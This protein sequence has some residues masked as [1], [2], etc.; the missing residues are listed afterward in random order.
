MVSI[1]RMPIIR[2]ILRHQHMVPR[3]KTGMRLP[4]RLPSHRTHPQTTIVHRTNSNHNKHTKTHHHNR[5]HLHHQNN[6]QR[7]QRRTNQRTAEKTIKT[8]KNET[9]SVSGPSKP[10]YT[11][12]LTTNAGGLGVDGVYSPARAPFLIQIFR[13]K[14]TQ[15]LLDFI[16]SNLSSCTR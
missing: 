16:T 11:I 14:Q 3:E 10:Y 13:D 6:P 15:L 2:T 4:I 9:P 1:R 8:W 12:E 5:H 7:K